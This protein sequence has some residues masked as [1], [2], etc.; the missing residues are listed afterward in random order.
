MWPTEIPTGTSQKLDYT[1]ISAWGHADIMRV[2]IL[3]KLRVITKK[4][5]KENVQSP[6]GTVYRVQQSKLSQILHSPCRQKMGDVR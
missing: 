5:T 1:N 3:G 4:Y 2:I 6:L